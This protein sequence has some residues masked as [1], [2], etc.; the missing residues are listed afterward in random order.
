M[1][2]FALYLISNV[3]LTF[4]IPVES[5]HVFSLHAFELAVPIS[6]AFGF[7]SPLA[8]APLMTFVVFK[9]SSLTRSLRSAAL[10][11]YAKWVLEHGNYS[12]KQMLHYKV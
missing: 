9:F 5:P 2:S 3:S 10:S 4:F 8:S 1:G 12:R 11:L 7:I 6:P